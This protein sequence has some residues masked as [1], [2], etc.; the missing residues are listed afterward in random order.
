MTKTWGEIVQAL[1]AMRFEDSFDLIAAIASGGIVPAALVQQR[2]LVPMF[3]LNINY[4]GA[5]HEPL[6]DKPQLLAPLP[7]NPAGRRILVVEDRVKTGA[8]I[9]FAKELLKEAALLKT[10]A[11]NG[12]ADYALFNEECFAFPWRL[13]GV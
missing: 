5:R 12:N 4:R 6:Y 3:V 2:L 1:K 13:D 7:F 10:F 9:M 8:T 11:V